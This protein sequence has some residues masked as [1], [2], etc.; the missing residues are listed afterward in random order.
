MSFGVIDEPWWDDRDVYI[1]GGGDSLKGRQLDKLHEKG[2]VLGINRAAELV[3][4]HAT[5]TLDHSFIRNRTAIL[6]KWAEDGQ[7]VYLAVG[8]GWF[9]EHKPI[10][11]ATYL[12][13]VQGFG[14]GKNPGQIVNG[15]NSGYGAVCLAVLKRARRIYMLGFDLK[16]DNTHWHDGYSWGNNRA[17]IYFER[18][19]KRYGEIREDLPR[20]VR[21]YNCNPDS[22]IVAFPFSTYDSIG[23]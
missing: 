15:L 21:V 9:G 3:P 20:G 7:E 19:A 17:C 4:C 11:G 5:F 23:I 16:G 10:P 22:A 18:W 1:I 8:G 14:V 6:Q 13:R 2:L 12:T